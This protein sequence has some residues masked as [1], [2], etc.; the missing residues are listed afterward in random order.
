M[1]IQVLVVI[2]LLVVSF[3]LF[4]LFNVKNCRNT[5]L[6]AAEVGLVVMKLV[7]AKRIDRAH[8]LLDCATIP[9]LVSLKMVLSCAFPEDKQ[10]YMAI[11]YAHARRKMI[12]GMS[13]SLKKHYIG[14]GAQVVVMVIM[15][16]LH[17]NDF[18]SAMCCL[19]LM[20][21]PAI[22]FILAMVRV[23]CHGGILAGQLQALEDCTKA[24]CPWLEFPTPFEAADSQN[25]L[26]VYNTLMTLE[27]KLLQQEKAGHSVDRAARFAEIADI[28]PQPP[29]S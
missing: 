21:L 8:K 6:A 1:L 7:L 25:L 27:K 29:H 23:I 24:W 9:F 22:F 10:V 15:Y 20:L 3:L 13:A 26:R 14:M 19:G 4:I 18:Y 11:V 28:L 5:D 12:D 17:V 16:V 2:A